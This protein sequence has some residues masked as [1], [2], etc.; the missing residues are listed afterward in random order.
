MNSTLQSSNSSSYSESEYTGVLSVQVTGSDICKIYEFGG[1]IPTPY[2]V[3]FINFLLSMS[4]TFVAENIPR[5]ILAIAFLLYTLCF[6]MTMRTYGRLKIW[7]RFFKNKS[8]A[9]YS[10]SEVEMGSFSVASESPIDEVPSS[11]ETQTQ[12]NVFYLKLPRFEN[13]LKIVNAVWNLIVTIIF[14]IFNF[15]VFSSCIRAV[16]NTHYAT[17][18]GYGNNTDESWLK[19]NNFYGLFLN[20]SVF[21]MVAYSICR[22]KYIEFENQAGSSNKD[23]F[24]TMCERLELFAVGWMI[25][26]ILILS[27]PPLLTHCLVGLLLFLWMTILI[28]MFFIVMILCCSPLFFILVTLFTNIENYLKKIIG[29]E[30]KP[31]PTVKFSENSNSPEISLFYRLYYFPS[32]G[33]EIPFKKSIYFFS[34]CAQMV[35][36]IFYGIMYLFYIDLANNIDGTGF[37][38]NYRRN[39]GKW[40]SPPISATYAWAFSHEVLARFQFQCYYERS[41]EE[42]NSFVYDDLLP[43]LFLLD[44]QLIIFWQFFS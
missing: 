16:Q 2:I 7:F 36:V 8:R 1:V 30:I 3:L 32:F 5:F 13:I 34:V 28:L 17:E 35:L 9:V 41:I 43:S 21:T 27:I 26:F 42:L 12:S 15:A 19:Y 14:T 33:G 39:Y 38:A 31:E 25:L 23:L 22:V 6:Q 40:N 37:T 24:T 29:E 10:L 11:K 18:D 4:L 20:S 44:Q